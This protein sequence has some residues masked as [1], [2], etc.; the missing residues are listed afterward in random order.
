MPAEKLREV[1]RVLL[2]SEIVVGEKLPKDC[3]VGSKSETSDFWETASKK[4]RD[5]LNP[6]LM[7]AQ[8]NPTNS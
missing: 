3:V 7:S 6:F 8:Q 1:Q 4:I 2:S 5:F